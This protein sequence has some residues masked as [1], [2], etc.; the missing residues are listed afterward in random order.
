MSSS[1]PSSWEAHVERMYDKEF[2]K[3]Y[4]LSWLSFNKLLDMLNQDLKVVEYKM[5]KNSK[6]W[7]AHPTR[8]S[9]PLLCATSQAAIPSTCT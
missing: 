8:S 6:G 9:S 2:K 3:R 7:V 5:T 4:R 1:A